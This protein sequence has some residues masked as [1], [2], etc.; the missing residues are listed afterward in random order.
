MWDRVLDT[1][2]ARWLLDLSEREEDLFQ[3]PRSEVP[4]LDQAITRIVLAPA[5]TFESMEEIEDMHETWAYRY[6]CGPSSFCVYKDSF[7][8]WLD[9]SD[10]SP[11]SGGSAIYAAVAAFAHSQG[12][13]FIGDPKGL[14]D[15]A[16]RRRTDAMLSSALKYRCSRHL[17][18]HPRQVEG[19]K[20]LGVPPLVW[21]VDTA[22][23]VQN[24]IN[25]AVESLLFDVP[26]V[27]DA[28]YDF[29]EK[30][31]CHTQGGPLLEPVLGSWSDHLARSGKTRAGIATL[32]RGILLRSLVRQESSARPVLLEQVLR[33]SSDFITRGDLSGIFY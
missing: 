11:G 2:A 16:L 25:V 13:C 5:A 22:A 1:F 24:M 3:H 8:I 29:A 27:A 9:V 17:K 21:E 23:N 28:Y 33:E 20:E 4:D 10:C 19:D 30:A 12:Y 14:S 32:K 26:E 15:M 18:P 31:F 7:Q 6:Q